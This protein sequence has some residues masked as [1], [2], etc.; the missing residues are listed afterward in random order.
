M[1]GSYDWEFRRNGDG[2]LLV[3]QRIGV[4]WTDGDDTLRAFEPE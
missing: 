1:G 4:L 2:W 3:R